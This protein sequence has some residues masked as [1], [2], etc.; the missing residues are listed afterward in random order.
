LLPVAVIVVVNVTESG[1]SA[2]VLLSFAGV[3]SLL[4]SVL[5]CTV[6]I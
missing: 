6:P 4:C 5:D 3:I 2:L 1:C